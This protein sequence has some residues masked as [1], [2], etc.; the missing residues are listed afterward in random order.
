M[1]S[2]DTCGNNDAGKAVSIDSRSEGFNRIL[3]DVLNPVQFDFSD[4]LFQ[5]RFISVVLFLGQE[6]FI[7][8]MS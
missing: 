4:V 1:D 7:S 3:A 6:R 5:K 8:V 2:S